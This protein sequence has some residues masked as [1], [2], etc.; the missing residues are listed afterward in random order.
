MASAEAEASADYHQRA[1]LE[2]QLHGLPNDTD[3]HTPKL[4]ITIY[5]TKFDKVILSLSSICAIIAGA[6]NPLVPVIYGVIVS[7]FNSFSNGSVEASKL[8]SEISTF[9]LYYVY[10]SIAL[11]IFTY[12]GTLGFYFSG[13]RIA[14]A[15]RIAYLEA[16]IRQNMAFFDVLRPGEISNRIM[17]DMG[18]LQEAI[19]SK[20]SIMLSAVATFCA[21]FI[22][23]FIMYWKTALILSPFFATM[24]LMFS[25]GGSYSVKHQKVSRKKYSHAAGIP[26]EA[27]SAIRQVAAF[28]MQDFVKDKY[29]Q[30]L[31]EAAAAE[32]KAQTIVA[33]LIASMCAMPCLVYSLSFWTGSIFLV[34]GETSVASITSTTLAVTIGVFAIIRIAPSMQAFVSGIAISGSLFETISRRS[35]QDPLADNGAIPESLSGN[36]QLNNVGLV[37]PSRDQ[38]KVLDNVTLHFSA[39]KT[40]AIVGPSGGGKSSIL[41]LVERFYEPTSGSVSVDGNDIQSLNLRWLRQHIGLVDQDPVLLD[42]S[43]FENIWYGCADANDTTPESKRLDLVIDAAKKAYAHEFIMALPHGYQ[44]RVGEKGMQLSG[45]QRQ[46]IAITRAL[47]RDPKILLLDE[48]TSALDSASEKAIQAAIDIASKHRTTIIIAHRLST[49]R[50]ADLIVVLS[51][52]QVADQGTHDELMAR[53][54]LY[55][56]LI[57]KQQIKE[58]S[59]KEAGAS[60]GQDDEVDVMPGAQGASQEPE[61]EKVGA[62]ETTKVED[63]TNGDP[64]L[65]VPNKKGAFSFLLD[66]SKP[67]WKILAIGLIFSILAGLEIPAESIFFAKL[68]TIIGLPKNQYSQLRR[69]ANLWSGLYVALAAAGFVFWLGVGTTLTYA[70]QKLSKRVRE[71]CC[72]KITVQSMEF[73]DEAKN[74]PSALSNT[75]SKSTDDLAGMGGSVMGGILTF[76]A[77]IIGGIAVSLAVGW[78]LAL[79]CT[80]TIPVVVACGWLRLQVLAAFDAR[81]RQSG[82]D[83][84]AYAG[85]IVRSMRT[86]ASLGLEKRVLDMYGGFLSNHAAKSFRS[87]LVTSALYAASSSVVYLCAALG[88]WYGGI[89]I[90]NGEY[91]AFQVYVCFVCL[92]SGSQ[93]AGSIFTFAP[94]AGKAM[95]A[96]QELQKI[97]ELPDGEKGAA[98]ETTHERKTVLNNLLNGPDPWQVKFQDVSFAYP[99]RPH[100][101]ALNHFTV[102][103]EPGKTLALVGQSG[104]GK[105]TCL[106]L[107]ERFYALQQGQILV[108][109]Q[110]IRS[111][112]LNSY[113]QA[114]SLISQEAVIFSTSMRDNIAVGLVGQDI[115]DDEILA[116][117]R[118]ANILDFVN[119][120]PDG[121]ASA[122]GTGGSML[123]GGQKQR[124]AI[125]RAFLRKSKLLLLDEAT[126]ALDSESEAVVQTA[127][128]AVKKN[129]T[130]IMVAHRLSTVMNADVICVMREGSVAEIGSP[131]QL[132]ARRGLF[133]EMVNM[134]SLN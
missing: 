107:L 19:T 115:S 47:I 6:L 113:R 77:T 7:V 75:L 81:I 14:R 1:V 118:Q 87:I 98:I 124:I 4:N 26:E 40:T 112:D 74:S 44:T 31:K 65:S 97:A 8:R 101:P 117:C 96:A 23:S 58:E 52:G 104:S 56:D 103:V 82:V 28:G 18:I 53:N 116:A 29:S 105:S 11:F 100:K 20:T 111:L 63:T 45:G 133:W 5:A 64:S 16:V 127:I 132:L 21:A 62:T 123:S 51:R 125:A 76:T 84:A 69:D 93:I 10:L 42:A 15:L 80:A 83:S 61:N 89:L 92:I 70:T 71:T 95:H 108:D 57:E 122:V 55:A 131:Q 60:I 34:S 48:A 24:L 120:L 50:N 121:L 129:R 9:S 72:D 128:E 38:V 85:Q 90:A 66:M 13:D 27:F 119:S 43:I 3:K 86:V 36:I 33:C 134:Q 2:R 30:G 130:T 46:R 37:Y 94:D 79:V 114:I 12:L 106:A 68:L 110:D 99:T 41:G 32:R 91:S 39:N 73:F 25:V 54:G 109:G 126:S 49:I 78:K 102:S 22:I 88:F 67:D 59:Q 35:P 17:S